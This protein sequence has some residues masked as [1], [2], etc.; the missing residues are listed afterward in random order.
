M[1]EML[2]TA[3]RLPKNVLSLIALAMVVFLPAAYGQATGETVVTHLEG[4]SESA[5][6]A[7]LREQA[8]RLTALVR[9]RKLS[10]AEVAAIDLQKKFERTFDPKVKQ[11]SFQS[12]EEYAEFRGSSVIAFE[13]IDWGYKECLQ[14]QAFI[15]ADRRDFPAA[16]SILETVEAVAPMS[17]G[18]S[19]ER[20]YVLNQLGRPSEALAAYRRSHALAT[21]YRAQRPYLAVALRGIGFALIELQ[22]I[23][24][25]EAA[26]HESLSIEPGNRVALHELAYI[27]ELRGGK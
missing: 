1:L 24:E 14:V 20:G 21:R 2:V 4:Y 13:W 17:A 27:R 15:A 11:Y 3:R 19:I 25:A 18:A 7:H 22:R 9:E 10:E 12:K 23:E 8:N 6:G 26:F 16:L 5:K